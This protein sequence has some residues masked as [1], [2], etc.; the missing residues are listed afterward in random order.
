VSGPGGVAFATAEEVVFAGVQWLRLAL[1]TVGAVVVAVGAVRGMGQFLASRR[2]A[3]EAR[4]V[5]VRLTLARYLS[6][7]LEFQLA[8]DILSTAIAPS[9]DQ[10]GKLAAIAV[11]RTGLN[12]FLAQEVRS[13]EPPPAPRTAGPAREQAPEAS[14]P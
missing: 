14:L 5:P 1:E 4:F 3:A 10:I 11:I 9:W 12:Y 13:E 2:A 8:A 7:A 6:L